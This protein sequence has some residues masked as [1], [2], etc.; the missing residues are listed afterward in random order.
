MWASSPSGGRRPGVYVALV[1]IDAGRF[2]ARRCRRSRVLNASAF[3]CVPHHEVPDGDISCFRPLNLRPTITQH[4]QL[5]A[6]Q[7]SGPLQEQS[8][9][10]LIRSVSGEFA[11]ATKPLPRGKDGFLALC[12]PA[13]DARISWTARSPIMAPRS[14]P[15]T[16]CRSPSSNFTITHR[17]RCERRRQGKAQLERS[18][19]DGYGRRM[20][21]GQHEHDEDGRQCGRRA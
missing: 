20:S 2:C 15:A 3:R 9:L 12:R 13:A 18:R 10:D 16:T 7:K 5:A 8:K 1:S 14:M 11:K 6:P 21:D 17:R 4:P 19:P